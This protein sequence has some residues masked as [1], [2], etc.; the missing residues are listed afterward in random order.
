MLPLTNILAV[1]VVASHMQNSRH[2]QRTH[3]NTQFFH[4]L[5]IILLC[6]R[7]QALL[8]SHTQMYFLNLCKKDVIS[9]QPQITIGAIWYGWNG[10]DIA[11]GALKTY[12]RSRAQNNP[13][14]HES[15]SCKQNF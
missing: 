11:V 9:F 1:E 8:R 3:L 13:H 14:M 7:T 10:D 5:W 6:A 2:V 4:V 12:P 15:D